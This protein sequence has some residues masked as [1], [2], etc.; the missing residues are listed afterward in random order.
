MTEPAM[1]GIRVPESPWGGSCLLGG[2]ALFDGYM[3]SE[4]TSGGLNKSL[5][6]EALLAT[7]VSIM[8]T[9]TH[10]YGRQAYLSREI[11]RWETAQARP[12]WGE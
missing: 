3:S 2:R 12:G 5:K 9:D 11:T 10:T 1:E 8:G 4:H 7:A 6:I